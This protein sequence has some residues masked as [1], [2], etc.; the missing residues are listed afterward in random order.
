MHEPWN[1]DKTDLARLIGQS[2]SLRL[3]FKQSKLF[4]SPQGQILDNLTKEVSAFANTEG[5]TIV[6]GIIED[7]DRR[8]FVAKALDDGVDRVKFPPE[9]LQQVLESNVRPMPAGLRVRAIPLSSA[10]V[11]YIVYVPAGTTAYQ[12]KDYYYYGRSEFES[13]P[14]ADHEIRLRMFRGKAASGIILVKIGDVDS[15]TINAKGSERPP[16]EVLEQMPH[17]PMLAQLLEKI[18]LSIYSFVFVLKNTSEVNIGEFKLDAVFPLDNTTK[19]HDIHSLYRA[20]GQRLVM[21]FGDIIRGSLDVNIFPEDTYVL[22]ATR[23]IHCQKGVLFP[24]EFRLIVNWRLF[25]RDTMPITGS[26]DIGAELRRL[27]KSVIA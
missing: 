16:D 27:Q 3:D 5:G 15:M 11:A 12:A 21:G 8:P 19:L 17:Y 13:K 18:E 2:E 26:I 4:D 22:D 23:K 1:W 10:G 20:G 7:R 9:W 24:D 25:L 6:V 14:L